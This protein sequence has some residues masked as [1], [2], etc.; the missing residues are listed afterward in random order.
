MEPIDGNALAGRL[1][2]QIGWDATAA[3]ARCLHCAA[4]DEIARAVVY[5][6]R[7]GEVARCGHCDGVLAVFVEATD[8]RSWFSMTGVAAVERPAS[9]TGP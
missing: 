6:T 4:N 7:M 9:I 2:D 3:R 8:G 1:A 5:A